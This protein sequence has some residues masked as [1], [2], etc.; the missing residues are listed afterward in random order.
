MTLIL[1]NLLITLFLILYFPIHIIRLIMGSKYRESTLPRLGFQN[2]PK[3]D[4]SRKTFLIHSVSVGETQ[5]A[6]TL[7]VELKKMLPDCRIFVSTVTETGQAVASKLK[8]VDGHFYLPYD[9]WPLTNRLYKT[10]QPDAVI[11]VEN[12]LWLNY[13]HAAKLR[14]IPCYQ[15]NAKLSAS[16][17][18]SYKKF[19]KFGQLLFEP[20]HHFFVQSETFRQRFEDMGIDHD[21]LTVSGN[22]KLDSN[23]PVLSTAD[24][25]EFKKSLGL[26]NRDLK[27]CL[28]Y[29][30]THAG[31]EELAL[32]VHNTLKSDFP[33]L[34]TIIVPRHPERFD[35]VCSMLE[36]SGAKFS[37]AS[38]IQ[39]DDQSE[40]ILIIDMMG[41][42]MKVYQLG[43]IG[44]VCGS[45]TG[46][47]GSHNFLEPA[48]Y[49]KPF[50]FGPHTYSQPGFYQLCQQANAGLQ[51]SAEELTD[52]LRQLLRDPQKQL[53]IGEGGH[54]IIAAAKGAVH[55]TVEV[56]LKELEN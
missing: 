56:I 20:M 44:I 5:V 55:H 25:N 16:S 28:I 31:E 35:G 9:L 10:I 3:A 2:Y 50:V 12:D 46:K 42:L 11:I 19:A 51:C 49:K 15:V 32:E 27:N 4:K 1:Y 48:F 40:G 6:G 38:Q 36:K 13:L 41:A 24:L 7:A 39:S 18:R 21:K 26:Q 14:D 37:R 47:V 30:S 52:E 8:N 43:T 45:F 22:I 53:E 54:K 34:Q 33:D 29:G 23:P 17:L